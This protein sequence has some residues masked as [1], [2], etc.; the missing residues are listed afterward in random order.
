MTRK[1]AKD[2]LKEYRDNNEKQKALEARIKKRAL[3]LCKKYPDIDLELG[4]K[5]EKV[6]GIKSG[7]IHIYENLYTETYI[8]IMQR[9]EEHNERQSKIKQG[10]LFN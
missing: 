10:K 6:R 9:I 7:E 8:E 2:Y 4:H 3:E 1:T 5:K